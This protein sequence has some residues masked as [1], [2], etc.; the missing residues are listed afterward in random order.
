[1]ACWEG[2]LHG[3]RDITTLCTFWKLGLAGCLCRV[4]G[5]PYAGASVRVPHGSGTTLCFSSSDSRHRCKK[6]LFFLLFF[7]RSD[8]ASDCL[9]TCHRNFAVTAVCRKATAPQT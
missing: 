1:M 5:G 9:S 8:C 4:L 7:G 3:P 2:A 6:L